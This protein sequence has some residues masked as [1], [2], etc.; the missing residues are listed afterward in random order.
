MNVEGNGFYKSFIGLLY[1]WMNWDTE[2][3]FFCHL[4]C[5]VFVPGKCM[6][7]WLI[8]QKKP[9]NWRTLNKFN[10]RFCLKMVSISSFTLPCS[11]FRPGFFFSIFFFLLSTEVFISFLEKKKDTITIYWMSS[12]SNSLSKCVFVEW[13]RNH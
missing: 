2:G 1:E 11:W 6:K 3:F 5:S 13:K 9:S 10:L 4:V 12:K 8:E 7:F